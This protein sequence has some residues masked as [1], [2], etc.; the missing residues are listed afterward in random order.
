MRSYAFWICNAGVEWKIKDNFQNID[1][2]IHTKSPSND[3]K[4]GNV[5]RMKS[6]GFLSCSIMM[7]RVCVFS[8]NFTIVLKL[9]TVASLW[10]HSSASSTIPV[11]M[12][13]TLSAFFLWVYFRSSALSFLALFRKWVWMSPECSWF[14]PLPPFLQKKYD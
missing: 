10:A 5:W 7:W 13:L 14:G 6:N 11:G 8:M 3:L 2:K 12:L 1:M 4:C 9:A